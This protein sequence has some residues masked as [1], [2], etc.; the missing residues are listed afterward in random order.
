MKLFREE[1]KVIDWTP[2]YSKFKSKLTTDGHHIS[3][4]LVRTNSLNL[5]LSFN[6]LTAGQP[7]V[8]HDDPI[9]AHGK[10]KRR[11]I[12]SVS[13][14]FRIGNNGPHPCVCHISFYTDTCPTNRLTFSI[15]HHHCDHTSTHTRW[16]WRQFK[17][18]L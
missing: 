6:C 9:T 18:N 8:N 17:L 12:S 5:K 1:K 10:F 7:Y 11:L 3:Y 2:A 13:D 14:P 15:G 4:R 16:L